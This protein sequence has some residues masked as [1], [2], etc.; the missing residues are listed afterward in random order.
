MR[1]VPAILRNQL[2]GSST[3]LTGSIIFQALTSFALA[4]KQQTCIVFLY[5]SFSS[6][7]FS[8]VLPE[9]YTLI[10]FHNDLYFDMKSFCKNEI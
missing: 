1:P 5:S 10:P 3:L 2:V 7:V 8:E 6:N 4:S 9:L